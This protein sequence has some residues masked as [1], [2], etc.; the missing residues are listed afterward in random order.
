MGGS[1]KSSSEDSLAS[2][3]DDSKNTRRRKRKARKKRDKE[4]AKMAKEKEKE[5]ERQRK[6]RKKKI[7]KQPEVEVVI[8]KLMGPD[9][10][11]QTNGGMNAFDTPTKP[12]GGSHGNAMANGG[13]QRQPPRPQDSGMGMP[14]LLG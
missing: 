7:K 5:K 13:Q 10:A 3:S 11:E 8:P 4:K 6:E 2:D 1:D 12:N 9:D 14:N